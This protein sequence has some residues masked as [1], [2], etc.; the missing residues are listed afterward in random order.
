MIMVEIKHVKKRKFKYR[1]QGA[2]IF[3][4]VTKDSKKSQIVN[5]QLVAYMENIRML[6]KEGQLYLGS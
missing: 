2:K 3:K 6:N 5:R 1:S 4:K